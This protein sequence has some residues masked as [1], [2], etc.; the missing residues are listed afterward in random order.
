MQRSRNRK[1]A[2]GRRIASIAA[3]ISRLANQARRLSV[4]YPTIR[5]RNLPPEWDGLRIAHL[6]DLHAGG[7]VSLAFLRKAIRKANAARP[8]IIVLTGDFVDDPSLIGPELIEILK[9]LHAPEGC[10]AVLGNHDYDVDAAAVCSAL[11]AAGMRILTNSY[12]ILQRQEARLCLAGVDDLWHDP[13]SAESILQGVPPAV[14]RILL[15]HNPDYAQTIPRRRRVDLMLCGH[16]H[17]GQIKLP[18]LPPPIA[19]IR[20][21]KYVAGL[22][23]APA[24]PVYTSRGIGVSGLA[25]RFNCPPELPIITLRRG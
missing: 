13:A 2:L 18:L 16:T 25:V 1:S 7:L 20:H 11:L 12:Q 17:G 21:R 23:Q 14:P 10:F 8:D 5:L 3:A 4:T 15:S 9:G 22:R 6:S 19:R 24:C